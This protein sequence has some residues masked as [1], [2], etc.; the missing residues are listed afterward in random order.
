MSQK[1]FYEVLG[2]DRNAS[3]EEIKKAYKDNCKK[4]HPDR[5]QHLGDEFKTFAD[6]KIKQVNEAYEVLYK[7][8]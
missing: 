8:S 2:V 7:N 5:V 4:Y 6:E 1:D 3:A